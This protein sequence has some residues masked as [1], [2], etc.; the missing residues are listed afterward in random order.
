MIC[1]RGKDS[2][3]AGAKWAINELMK[4]L[5]HPNTKSQIRARAILLPLVLITMLIY[6]LKNP[7]FG[8][9]NLG[10]IRLADAKSSSG[11]IYLTYCQSRKK[12]SN[13]DFYF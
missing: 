3:K 1:L 10:D 6:N 12:V 5:W 9:R 8:M 2:F 7:F 13:E 11:L 4:N